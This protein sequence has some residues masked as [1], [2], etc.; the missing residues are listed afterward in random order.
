M[1]SFSSFAEEILLIKRAEAEEP[2]T[3]P[4]EASA[5]PVQDEEKPFHT[6]FLALAKKRI[7]SGIPYG[8]GYGLGAAGGAF[9][10][11]KFIPRFLPQSMNEATRRNMGRAAGILGAMSSLA[12][13][14]AIRRANQV[15][16]NAV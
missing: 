15:E 16:K 14:E 3:S 6:R 7:K 5:A 10:G 1:P 9:L 13:L 2:Q 8:L 11:H 4:V 12:T